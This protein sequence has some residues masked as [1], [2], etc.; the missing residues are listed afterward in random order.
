MGFIPDD[1]PNYDRDNEDDFE[2]LFFLE[3]IS[4]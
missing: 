4:S 2:L 1:M 3:R